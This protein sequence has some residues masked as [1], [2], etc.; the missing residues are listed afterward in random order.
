[1]VEQP[2]KYFLTEKAEKIAMAMQYFIE[3]HLC[4][5]T[6]RQDHSIVDFTNSAAGKAMDTEFGLNFNLLKLYIVNVMSPD[7][8]PNLSDHRVALT[9]I[10]CTYNLHPEVRRRGGKAVVKEWAN[11]EGG[12]LLFAL[13][14]GWIEPDNENEEDD[15][16]NEDPGD[17]AEE[18]DSAAAEA[19]DGPEDLDDILLEELNQAYVDLA[20]NPEASGSADEPLPKNATTDPAVIAEGE[21][22]ADD[23]RR[24][25]K[26]YRLTLPDQK[27]TNPAKD[28]AKEL[29]DL[30][31][32]MD[33][34][35]CPTVA[36]SGN[37]IRDKQ[38]ELK[39][40]RK[41]ELKDSKK[42]RVKAGCKKPQALGK[43]ADELPKKGQKR[44]DPEPNAAEP[45]TPSPGG[46]VHRRAEPKSGPKPSPPSKRGGRGRKPQLDLTQKQDKA[47]QKKMERLRVS[48]AKADEMLKVV[49]ESGISDLQPDRKGGSEGWIE[50]GMEQAR[51]PG[52]GD[53]AVVEMFSGVGSIA[54]GF[55]HY[56]DPEPSAPEQLE[57]DCLRKSEEDGKMKV[58]LDYKYSHGA[59]TDIEMTSIETMLKK[60]QAGELQVPALDYD[61]QE[62]D[63]Q[64]VQDFL[65]LWSY[66]GM[67]LS[68]PD[69]PK[70]RVPV[71]V[72]EYLG[73]DARGYDLLFMDP[74]AGPKLMSFGLRGLQD[75]FLNDFVEDL[76]AVE[77]VFMCKQA[78]RGAL[79]AID[80]RRQY[81][82]ELQKR[83]AAAED[84]AAKIK[85]G[86][87]GDPVKDA[88]RQLVSQQW[89]EAE[90]KRLSAKST[91]LEKDMQC[92]TD[93]AAAR[94]HK[95]LNDLRSKNAV[96]TPFLDRLEVW[97]QMDASQ[98]VALQVMR[99]TP[100]ET[101]ED[102][103]V[104]KS[105]GQSEA[106]VPGTQPEPS[107]EDDG[108]EAELLSHTQRML[109]LS[110]K[111]HG[112]SAD[113]PDGLY[114]PVS[115]PNM[116]DGYAPEP[117]QPLGDGPQAGDGLKVS[118]TGESDGNKAQRGDGAKVSTEG[119]S[120]GN[121]AQA[122]GDGLKVSTEGKSDGDKAQAGD[123]LKI[124]T[125][126]KSDGDKAH[127]DGGKLST[128]GTSD[129][130][131]AQAG[132]GGKI[133]TEG[134]SDGDKA[135]AGDGLKVSTEGMSDGNK[136]QDGGDA[137]DTD[138]LI[139]ADDAFFEAEL[140][141]M[142]LKATKPTEVD[143][144]L[145]ELQKVNAALQRLNTTDIQAI[146]TAAPEPEKT[147]DTGKQMTMDP[148]GDAA[149]IELDKKCARNEY[150]NQTCPDVILKKAVEGNYSKAV[151]SELFNDY[152]KA[153]MN[154]LESDIV[155]QAKR[156]SQFLVSGS[157]NFEL[158][159]DLVAKHGEQKANELRMQK[160]MEQKVKGDYA[161]DV[162]HWMTHP[163]FPGDEAYEM[164]LVFEAAR[165]TNNR[166]QVFNGADSAPLRHSGSASSLP[167]RLA[168]N[169]NTDF[170]RNTGGKKKLPNADV[171][172]DNKATKATNYGAKGSAKIKDARSL[173][174]DAKTWTH[175]VN[176]ERQK[177]LKGDAEASVSAQM[178]DGYLSQIS[179]LVETLSTTIDD[180]EGKIVQGCKD[181]PITNVPVPVHTRDA[182]TSTWRTETR[183]TESGQKVI[184][185]SLNF[186]LDDS[187]QRYPLFII[188]VVAASLNYVSHGIAPARFVADPSYVIDKKDFEGELES[189][190][191]RS[192]LKVH[193]F[194]H[195]CIKWCTLHTLNLGV[196]IW[197]AASAIFE[198]MKFEARVVVTWLS[199]RLC[200]LKMDPIMDNIPRKERFHE[201]VKCLYWITEF[202][203]LMDAL[204]RLMNM[205][206]RKLL[207]LADKASVSYVKLSK[208][209]VDDSV[210]ASDAIDEHLKTRS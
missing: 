139:I 57:Y 170:V 48:Q 73:L 45:K 157:R 138:S 106:P 111:F 79:D 186:L 66:D 78:V 7:G 68:K 76:E 167:S 100:E 131:K 124:S 19:E 16:I 28:Y 32:E 101:L 38:R 197:A 143:V 135:Q 180:L 33:D 189:D 17:D 13:K 112:D 172:K 5:E 168:G 200:S 98:R 35:G 199:Y 88:R 30:L 132:D 23:D 56:P 123:G 15:L 194:H 152:M 40:S 29:Q 58:L 47:D 205:D 70:H 46:L 156:K 145:Q 27:S 128:E 92:A 55:H 72:D 191:S 59:G 80:D 207:V 209:A 154:W 22:M 158:Y 202:F 36:E 148:D 95:V 165:V 8:L 119:E 64:P 178:C 105:P 114:G 18:E 113:D 201:M 90:L 166:P 77:V 204:P 122:A 163:D 188:R 21:T 116:V 144:Q 125:E 83:T 85:A 24:G 42:A 71:Y 210:F 93:R 175:K 4:I 203:N 89:L 87:T 149:Q 121:K 43:E 195:N 60:V 206:E 176:D 140:A 171:N 65:Q 115:E 164:F 99:N 141:R 49:R 107:L 130:D 118:T 179:F 161:Q 91:E 84:A 51:R 97:R 185:V 173:L 146:P 12:R 69:Q 86:K 44:K 155:I 62:A 169:E 127:G 150:K 162:P 184:C 53:V 3:K 25:F 193:G 182:K 67:A 103:L 137:S 181:V 82:Q 81:E 109:R 96:A 126:G 160:K 31:D 61:W 52:T 177:G 190:P 26:A 102:T 117:D 142:V 136:A 11:G 108:V 208:M 104:D 1:M 10:S 151:M 41:E 9:H 198:L 120:D 192:L 159:K 187:Q 129:G 6:V 134:K 50:L 20:G 74:D 147:S 37:D 63:L 94:L 54:A 14:M 75:F 110:S 39:A 133:S 174:T 34:D 196:A 2:M 183:F 153:G